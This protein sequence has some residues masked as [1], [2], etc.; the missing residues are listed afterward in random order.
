M[1]PQLR[2][3]H[4]LSPVSSPSQHVGNDTSINSSIVPNPPGRAI[5][6]LDSFAI[7]RFLVCISPTTV[8]RPYEGCSGDVSYSSNAFG[9]IPCTSPP[10]STSR[11]ATAPIIPPVPPPYTTIR[12]DTRADYQGRSYVCRRFRRDDVLIRRTRG[13]R[14]RQRRRRHRYC[15]GKKSPWMKMSMKK[16]RSCCFVG[17]CTFV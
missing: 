2:P 1:D 14:R 15:V 16:L 17:V 8:V 12:V 13:Q 5:N 3:S 9:I 10:N 6:A 11:P 4:H 7:S